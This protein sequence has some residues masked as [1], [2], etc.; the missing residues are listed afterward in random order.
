MRSSV[1]RSGADGSG[2]TNSGKT[3]L[4]KNLL[5]VLQPAAH[6]RSPFTDAHILHQDDFTYP[7]DKMPYNERWQ[8]TDWDTPHGSVRVRGRGAAHRRSTMRACTASWRIS[9]SMR[10][11]RRTM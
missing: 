2:A 4:A 1:R 6:E 11:C 5:G 7:P 8:I 9:G 3:T 10:A